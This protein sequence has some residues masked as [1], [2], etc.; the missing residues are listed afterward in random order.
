MKIRSARID[1]AAAVA[2]IMNQVIRDTTFSFK[3]QEFSPSD[4]QSQIA[5]APAFFVAV[6]SAAVIGF[7]TYDQFRKGPGYART[8][9]HT[10]MLSPD[11]KGRG[12]GRAL[13]RVVENHA[14]DAGVGSLWAG[15]SSENSEGISFH[16]AIGF[17]EVALLPK[18]GFKFD[19]WLDL[20][21]MRK[22][23]HQGRDGAEC[24]D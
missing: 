9:E 8:M 14:E 18:V 20:V 23:I 7:V 24:S 4:L 5:T 11:A 10:I 16:R 12:A 3:S 1:D 21:L 6:D 13:M 22:W 17:E 19:R 15:I 2:D